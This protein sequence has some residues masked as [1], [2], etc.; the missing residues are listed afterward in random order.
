MKKDKGTA[1]LL[2]ASKTSI[3]NLINYQNQEHFSQNHICFAL[4]KKYL[5][6]HFCILQNKNHLKQIVIKSKLLFFCKKIIKFLHIVHQYTFLKYYS[7]Y[8]RSI[9]VCEVN[10][11][12]ALLDFFISKSS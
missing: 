1:K 10:D 12:N 4:L 6:L 8:F 3:H 9:Q 7:Y 11:I 2:N 5:F